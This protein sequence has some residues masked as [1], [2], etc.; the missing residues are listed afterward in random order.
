[1]EKSRE[2]L[3]SYYQKELSFLR[4]LGQEF[5]AHFPDIAQHLDFGK[6]PSTDP[7][8]ER[9]LESFA[10]L[11]GRLQKQIDDLTPEIASALLQTLYPSFTRPIPSM[12]LFCFDLDFDKSGQTPGI[13][14]KK[15]SQLF[16]NGSDGSVCFF[17]TTH[18]LNLWPVEILHS[19]IV[20]PEEPLME[21]PAYLHL[22]VRWHGPLG[23]GPERLRFYLLGEDTFKNTLYKALFT[24]DLPIFI[25]IS[26]DN[27]LQKIP[28]L[29]AIGFQDSEN[30]LPITHEEH[31]GFRFLE[32]YFAFPQKFL[33]AEI[34]SIPLDNW[35]ETLSFYLPMSEIS[36]KHLEVNPRS[37]EFN[38]VPGINLFESISEPIMLDYTRTETM[39]IP[40]QRRYL[41]QEVYSI[42]R[43]VSL[44]TESTQE[45][46]IPPYHALTYRIQQQAPILFWTARRMPSER[47]DVTGTDVFLSF[48]NLALHPEHSEHFVIYAHTLCTNRELAQ[49]IP[50][51]GIF[52]IEQSLPIKK[53][54]CMERPTTVKSPPIQGETLWRLITM[55]SLES[56]SLISSKKDNT[57]QRLKELLYVLSERISPYQQEIHALSSITYTPSTRR[58]GRDGWRGFVPGQKITLEI[59]DAENSSVNTILFS[60]VLAEFFRSYTSYNSF[61]EISVKDPHKEGML[62]TWPIQFGQQKDL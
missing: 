30:L 21:A 53:I 11:T 62:K 1:M 55:L 16:T 17:R 37:L 34:H 38:C 2:I 59:D 18:D 4:T 49:E 46:E 36:G 31:R 20:L 52:Q 19:Q 42:S 25:K 3:V 28:S 50:A 23:Q 60:G 54:F 43:V 10:L 44:D 7:H 45:I 12:A 57:L 24:H 13:Y 56:L 51:G 40:D 41:T 48:V 6:T 33:G 47:M 27:I 26:E 29:Q 32:E 8:V 61:V 14:V 58:L 15:D 22:R 35:H 9:L 5:S 39:I